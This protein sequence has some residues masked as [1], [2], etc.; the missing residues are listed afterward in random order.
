MGTLAEGTEH[1]AMAMWENPTYVQVW[2]DSMTVQLKA[3][4]IDCCGGHSVNMFLS[5][6]CWN[7]VCYYCLADD[8]QSI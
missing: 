8:D 1:V 5:A 3:I 4:F 6:N 7:F 2:H